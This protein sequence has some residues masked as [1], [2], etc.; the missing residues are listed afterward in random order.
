MS[1]YREYTT[2]V[3]INDDE[4]ILTSR[5]G[6]NTLSSTVARDGSEETNFKA[7]CWA[8]RNSVVSLPPS[9]TAPPCYVTVHG[10][11]NKAT[12]S[13]TVT[14]AT[15]TIEVPAGNSGILS[16]IL[17]DDSFVTSYRIGAGSWVAFNSGDTITI[18]DGQ[19]LSFKVDS[20]T[21]QYS[22]NGTVTDDDTGVLIDAISLMNTSVAP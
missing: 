1:Q 19:L 18:T 8:H 5:F 13:G 22:I 20:L 4:I 21:E 6:S 17:D 7:A 2:S 15:A 9:S 11:W 14:T 10:R 16:V 3:F 12:A